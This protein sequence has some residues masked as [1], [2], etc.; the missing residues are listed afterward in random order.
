MNDAGLD[1]LGDQV[2]LFAPKLHQSNF[3]VKL[4]RSSI[5]G[6]SSKLRCCM[7]GLEKSWYLRKKQPDWLKY[8]GFIF[9]ELVVGS[10]E[11][12]KNW[13]WFQI[14]N[15]FHDQNKLSHNWQY[16]FEGCF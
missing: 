1:L 2:T 6:F 13:A 5:V 7:K 4:N 14:E 10:N 9:S 3:V 15:L 11:Q 16:V 12:D 8:E